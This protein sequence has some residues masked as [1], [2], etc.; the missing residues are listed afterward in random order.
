M[1]CGNANVH[2][3]V[4][5]EGL[6]CGRL[7][8]A[9]CFVE[10]YA[11]GYGYVEAFYCT[12]HGDG[13]QGVAGFAGELAHALAFCAEYQRGGAAQVGLVEGFWCVVAGAYDPDIAL[14]EFI[15][16]TR[17]IGDHEVR[18]GFGSAAGYFGYG[19]VDAGGVVFRGDYGVCPCPVGY[20]QACAEIVRVGNAVEHEQ[21]WWLLQAVEQVIER[22]AGFNRCYPRYYALVPVV[23]SKA[24][25]AQAVGLDELHLRF[26]GALKKLPHA[27]IAPRGIEE[28]FCHCFG[29]GFQV[30][31]Y[32]MKAKY[33]AVWRCRHAGI[34]VVIVGAMR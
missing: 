16:G 23:A 1:Y 14:F 17:Q 13:Y 22:M 8:L 34:I 7:A 6:G 24:R 12:A 29:G 31:A 21:Q 5:L 28:Y 18:H 15:Q 9:Q 33:D 3:F 4:F 30:D 26:F 19:G 32:G 11:A 25:E 2:F 10:A 27:G 20:T